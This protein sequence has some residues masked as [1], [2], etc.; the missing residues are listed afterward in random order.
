LPLT[1]IKDGPQFLSREHLRL[2]F[3]LLV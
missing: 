1:I 2:V 3:M